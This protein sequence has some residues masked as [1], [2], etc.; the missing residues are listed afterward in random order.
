MNLIAYCEH[1]RA[2]G[3]KVV[4]GSENT[5]WRS[6]EHLSMLRQPTC[7]LHMPSREEMSN[8]FRESYAAMLSFT[9][10]SSEGCDANSCLY[11]CMD[12]EYS[13]EKLG[14]GARY[15]VR[16]G[17]AEFEITFLDQSDVLRLG[18]AAYCDTLARIGLSVEH[19]EAFEVAFSHP[20]ADTLYLGALRK[21][22]LAAFLLITHVDD[23]VSIGGYSASKFLPLRP[24]NALIFFATHHYLVERKLRVVDYGLSSIQAVSNADGLHKF[25]L[26]MGFESVP[27]HRAFIFNPL[28]RPFINRAS[29]TMVNGLLKLSPHHPILKKAEGALRIALGNDS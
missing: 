29:W 16:H 17:L 21:G 24:N 11:L 27:V 15:D 5:L 3:L 13:L 14:K 2:G 20:R 7:A 12:P 22:Q 4:V 8:V 23:W 25:K 18:K 26:K 1:L 6:H 28:L 9:L 10:K 19:R